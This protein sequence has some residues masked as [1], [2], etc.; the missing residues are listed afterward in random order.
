MKLVGKGSWENYWETKRKG[1]PRGG[2]KSSGETEKGV[3]NGSGEGEKSQEL[4]VLPKQT[5]RVLRKARKRWGRARKR[6]G[7]DDPKASWK[8]NIEEEEMWGGGGK[9]RSSINKKGEKK[10]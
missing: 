7:T 5:E 10:K 2:E 9:K 8:R 4:N 3:E 6:T 1:S